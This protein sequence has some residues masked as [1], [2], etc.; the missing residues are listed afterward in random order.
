MK[1]HLVI[2][3]LF[4]TAGV[5]LGRGVV[6]FKGWDDLIQR[7]PAIIIAR[8]IAT[9]HSL[10]NEPID[11]PVV[12]WSMSDAGSSYPIEVLT[13]LKGST[14]PGRA[15]MV[16]HYSPVDRLLPRQDDVFLFFAGY[17]STNQSKVIYDAYENYQV[18]CI[19]SDL[20][21]SDLTNNI[22]G[23][24]L[25]EQIRITAIPQKNRKKCWLDHLNLP[26]GRHEKQKNQTN[27]V[28]V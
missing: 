23:K 22:A 1:K 2:I 8:R 18:V 3:S 11:H 12:I 6:A 24:S 15:E 13:I 7:S 5:I 16:S 28:P 19:G 25:R 26:H 20:Y 9:P 21:Y 17:V 10:T 4:A 27:T 14:R